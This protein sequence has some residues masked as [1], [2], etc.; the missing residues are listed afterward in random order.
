MFHARV[1][2]VRSYIAFNS[3]RSDAEQIIDMRAHGGNGML[4]SSK[5]DYRIETY[6]HA[7]IRAVVRTG[8]TSVVTGNTFTLF[9]RTLELSQ[10]ICVPLPIL[11]QTQTGWSGWYRDRYYLKNGY[12]YTL[13]RYLPS[14]VGYR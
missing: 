7:E 2:R 10:T 8:A 11:R 13:S 12:K 4:K 1:L 5:T 9:A 14:C 3:R 6:P